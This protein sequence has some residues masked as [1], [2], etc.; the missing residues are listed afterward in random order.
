[1][2]HHT[3]TVAIYARSAT[4]DQSGDNTLG[5]QIAKLQ[6][7]CRSKKYS[8]TDSHVYEEIASGSDYKNRLA[9]T[10]LRE[11]AKRGEF[12][13]VVIVDYDRIARTH[14]LIKE[15]IAE[16]ATY[17]IRVESI[18]QEFPDTTADQF[19]IYAHKAIKDIE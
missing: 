6:A 19:A 11:A 9:M 2:S 15:L 17:G 1:V 12:E 16:M 3:T 18:R 5:L 7:Y 8:V 10:A 14:E 13:I 4:S